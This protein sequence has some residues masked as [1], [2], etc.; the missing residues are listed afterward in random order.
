VP[1]ISTREVNSVE[2]VESL[3]AKRDI[4]MDMMSKHPKLD[5]VPLE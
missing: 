5:N 4:L 3:S 1:H 2:E